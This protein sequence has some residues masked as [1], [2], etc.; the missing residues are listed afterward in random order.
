[1]K[2]RSSIKTLCK[3]CY[4]V[5]RGKIRYVYCKKNGKHKQRQGN[6]HSAAGGPCLCC[7]VGSEISAAVEGHAMAH[8]SNPLLAVGRSLSG[9]TSAPSSSSPFA[10]QT[11][12]FS[13]RPAT[14]LRQVS[15]VPCLES[16]KV[17]KF[18]VRSSVNEQ[19]ELMQKKAAAAMQSGQWPG[20]NNSNMQNMQVMQVHS[21]AGDTHTDSIISGLTGSPFAGSSG[22][23]TVGASRASI[24][25]G[26][27]AFSA[28][29]FTSVFDKT[30]DDKGY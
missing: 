15:E 1:M 30:A 11:R 25:A 13:S 14:T 26:L 24:R 10:M 28:S 22:V 6:F 2:V 5:K 3:H 16:T 21:L 29:G 19:R 20:A 7:P 8:N 12:T 18:K 17:V 23:V 4:V 27:E 9:P